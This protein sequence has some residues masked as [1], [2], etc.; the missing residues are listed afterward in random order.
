MCAKRGKNIGNRG[1]YM[2]FEAFE[3]RNYTHFVPFPSFGIFGAVAFVMS[4]FID[5]Q[6]FR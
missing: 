4:Y 2:S 3:S 1:L 6:L 5:I